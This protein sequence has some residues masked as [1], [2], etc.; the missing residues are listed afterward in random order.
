MIHKLL[1]YCAH[2]SSRSQGLSIP[3]NGCP[4]VDLRPSLLPPDERRKDPSFRDSGPVLHHSQSGCPSGFRGLR[5]SASGEE[6]DIGK[7]VVTDEDGQELTR[8][9][10]FG[11]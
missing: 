8:G 1:G 3:L 7:D 10:R 9:T 4:Q 6:S 2:N 11:P 5:D